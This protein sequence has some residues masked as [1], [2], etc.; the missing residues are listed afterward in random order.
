MNRLFFGGR[1]IYQV[2][3]LSIVSFLL[4]ITLYSIVFANFYKKFHHDSGYSGPLQLVSHVVHKHLA[5]EQAER[6]GTRQTKNS[7]PF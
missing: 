7:T 3:C 6:T 4:S 2:H 5:G 1:T